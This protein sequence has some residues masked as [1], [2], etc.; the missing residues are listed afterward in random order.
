M[1]IYH[2][3]IIFACTLCLCACGPIYKTE[4]TYQP[5][6]SNSGRMCAALCI[7]SKTNCQLMCSMQEGSCH[8]RAHER[9][10]ME[11]E[12]YK[13]Q[14]T[15]AGKGIDRSVDSFYDDWSCNK[16]CNCDESFNMC[17]QTC[18]GTVNS[19]QVCTAFCDQK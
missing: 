1:K 15:A 18:G 8:S 5:P 11:Y 16:E 10:I 12:I 7:Q 3:L 14:Q 2:W 9:A 6:K 19:Y 13:T 4:Y 17:Y